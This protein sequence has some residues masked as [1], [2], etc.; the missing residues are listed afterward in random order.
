MPS[1]ELFST[2]EAW[3]YWRESKEGPQRVLGASLPVKS[4][5]TGIVQPGEGNGQEG[6]HEGL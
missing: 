3:T 6:T 1:S 2:R 4:E 5:R